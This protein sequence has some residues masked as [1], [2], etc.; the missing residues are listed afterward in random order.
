MK[1]NNQL[2]I[3]SNFAGSL[4]IRSRKT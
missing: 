3:R 1:L 2:K 4:F